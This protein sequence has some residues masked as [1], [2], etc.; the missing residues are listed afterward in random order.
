[1][2]SSATR[3]L[4]W[5][6]STTFTNVV[7]ERLETGKLRPGENNRITDAPAIAS[8]LPPLVPDLRLCLG[9]SI[10]PRLIQLEPAQEMMK[11][12]PV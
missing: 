1:M 6:D 3:K 12:A 11:V 8:A 4:V 9:S 2:R 5:P 7:G 10:Q